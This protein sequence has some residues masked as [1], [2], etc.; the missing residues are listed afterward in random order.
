[1]D[2]VAL[3][4]VFPEYFGLPCKSSFHQ[5]L[6]HQNHPEQV[7]CRVDPFGL[8]PP[9]CVAVSS[10]YAAP[11]SNTCSSQADNNAR[12]LRLRCGCPFPWSAHALK[13]HVYIPP[14]LNL[15]D[16]SSRS[17]VQY[18]TSSHIVW[19]SQGY[20]EAHTEHLLADKILFELLLRTT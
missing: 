3:G 14:L 15:Q 5:I 9:L 10:I 7:T 16:T 12:K 2:K 20:H 1:V 4:Q 8:H 13:D 18:G 19:M 11:F 6:H 17:T